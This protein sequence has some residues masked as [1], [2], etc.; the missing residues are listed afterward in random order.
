M[1]NQTLTTLVELPYG[2]VVM[3]EPWNAPRGRFYV[4]YR[5]R[6]GFASLLGNGVVDE[7]RTISGPVFIAPTE[8]I[9][10]MYDA[11]MLLADRRDIEAPIDTGWPPLT[12]GID[13]PSPARPDDWQ[14][15]LL[16]AVVSEQS[17]GDAPWSTYRQ[18]LDNDGGR[19]EILRCIVG[20]RT[21]ATLL[22]TELPLLPAQLERLADADDAP[23]TVAISIG[24]RLPY[25]EGGEMHDVVVSSDAD[26][27]GL[28]SATAEAIRQ[29][30][31]E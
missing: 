26:L 29:S 14:D 24:N 28:V 27:Q 7:F 2:T 1:T 21:V 15:V 19:T 30:S 9:G 11:G 13:V 4:G 16:N 3:L 25:V 20:A 6:H 8:Q 5:T 23:V 22:V 18:V 12:I 17:D 10:G 31:A